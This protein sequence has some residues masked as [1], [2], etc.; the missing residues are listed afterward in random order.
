MRAGVRGEVQ[1]I[2]DRPVDCPCGQCDDAVPDI[3]R[4]ERMLCRGARASLAHRR[5]Q[6]HRTKER[7][8]IREYDRTRRVRTSVSP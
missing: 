1:R 5:R 8:R 7:A 4:M 6:I 3:L 2:I